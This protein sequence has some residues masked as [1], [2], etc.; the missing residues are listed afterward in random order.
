MVFNWFR[1]QYTES[2][3]SEQETPPEQPQ[4]TPPASPKAEPA[5]DAAPP[6]AEPNSPAVAEDY[7]AWAKA[8]YKNIQKQQ[9]SETQVSETAETPQP[10]AETAAPAEPVAV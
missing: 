8:A 3:S 4:D 10:E 6:T 1:R 9:Q 2:G 7:L 5:T